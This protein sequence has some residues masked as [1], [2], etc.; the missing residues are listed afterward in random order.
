[1]SRSVPPEVG[2]MMCPEASTVSG[3][4]P[5]Q[6]VRSAPTAGAFFAPVTHAAK[7]LENSESACS[8][9]FLMM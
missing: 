8:T 2:A 5:A 3:W 7:S 6:V 1:M 9:T 4:Q